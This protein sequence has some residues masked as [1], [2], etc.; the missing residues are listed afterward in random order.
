MDL[1]SLV[2]RSS[3]R[4]SG[5]TAR[6]LFSPPGGWIGV[7]LVLGRNRVA[8]AEPASEID[9]GAACRAERREGGLH[10][11]AADRAGDGPHRGGLLRNCLLRRGAHAGPP[12]LARTGKPSPSS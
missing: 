1:S 3:D 4:F 6:G 10:G 9:V 11:P 7:V 5:K 8:V 12:Q 2:A